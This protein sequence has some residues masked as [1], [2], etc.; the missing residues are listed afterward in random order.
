[1]P[2]TRKLPKF[3]DGNPGES[4]FTPEQFRRAMAAARSEI[5]AM[6]G[7]ARAV[8]LSPERRRAIAMQGVAARRVARAKVKD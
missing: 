3:F 8:K 2:R 5:G 1:M 4:E 6:G 7:K